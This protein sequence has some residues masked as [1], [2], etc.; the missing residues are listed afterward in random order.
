MDERSEAI[1]E[2]GFEAALARLEGVVARLEAGELPLEQALQAFEEGVAL[3][4]HC[5]E[6]LASAERR[7]EVLVREGSRLVERPYTAADTSDESS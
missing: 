1:S 2:L 7:I 3:T 6:Q 5:A 4:R